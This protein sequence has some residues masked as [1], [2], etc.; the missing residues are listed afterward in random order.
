MTERRIIRRGKGFATFVAVAAAAAGISVP[1][2]AGATPPTAPTVPAPT[3]VA[4]CGS[5]TV[6]RGAAIER[7]TRSDGVERHYRIRIPAS[8]DARLPVPL[9]LA[10]HG[11][12]EK[13]TRFEKVTRLSSLPAVVVYPDGLR[14]RSGEPSWQS[15][16]Y[17]SPTADDVGFTAAILRDV[18]STVCVDRARTYAVG[19]SNG[20]GFVALL[21]CRMP[22]EFAAFAA[23]SGAF[24]PESA[25]G[26]SSSA[27]VSFVEFHG[28][29]DPVI[30]YNGGQ[31]F[32]ETYPS[33]PQWLSGWTHRANCLDLPVESQI[34][35]YVTKV[36][37]GF[38]L[39]AGTEVTHYRIAGGGHRW[40]G[41]RVGG[42]S[43]PSDTIDATAVI[44]QF[45][46]RHPMR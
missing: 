33:I 23:V 14:G 42:S 2:V 16:P 39:P 25:Q 34:N 9:I 30:H 15:A 4:G 46:A 21:A 7:T 36:E 20:G 27:G 11:R 38:C 26:C 6:T 41:S 5:P 35:S 22:H 10:F 19:R 13:S 24:Y 3:P 37:W 29:A 44:W 32:A 40:P 45:F 43:G 12:N 31:K 18:R 8:Y 28:T 17:A 1:G